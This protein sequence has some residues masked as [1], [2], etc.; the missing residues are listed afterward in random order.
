M[1]SVAYAE[2]AHGGFSFSGTWWSFVFGVRYFWRHVPV[3][4]PAFWRSFL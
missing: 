4:K 1:I 2:N 3:S